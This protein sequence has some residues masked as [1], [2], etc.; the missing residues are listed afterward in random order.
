VTTVSPSSTDLHYEAIAG[1]A[2]ENQDKVVKIYVELADV[3][4]IP[5]DKITATL[6]KNSDKGQ[7]VVLLVHGLNNKVT[8]LNLGMDNTQFTKT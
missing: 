1:Y 7:D 2:W 6:L 4:T 5:K 3:G 8:F